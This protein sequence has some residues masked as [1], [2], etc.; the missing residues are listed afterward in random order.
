[1]AIQVKKPENKRRR[2]IDPVY[3]KFTAK[4]FQ[5]LTSTEFYDYFM[6]T[7]SQGNHNFQFTNKR[8]VKDV[9]TTWVDIIEATLPVL[10]EI[11]RN[12]RVVISQEEQ[13]I[14][15]V[16]ARRVDS[17]VVRH[18]CSHGNLVE[19]IDEDGNVIPSKIVNLFKE[20]SWDTYENRFVYTLLVK[21]FQFVD[22]R[23]QKIFNN[24]NDECG[25]NLIM[26][27]HAQTKLEILDMKMHL[28][29]QQIDDYEDTIDRKN[30][31][32]TRIKRMYEMLARLMDSRFAHEMN[33]FSPV[34]PPL[35]PTNA[36]KKN[37]LLRKCHVLWDFIWS[38]KDVGYSIEIVEQ[39]PEINE[40]FEQDIWN[41]I[42]FTYVILKGY[43]EDAR[44]RALDYGM[45]GKR[46]KFKPK[47]IK[48][49]V[50][51]LIKDYDLPD[52]EVRKVL[53]EELTKEQLLQ[54]EKEER[55]RLVEERER[56]KREKKRLEE[57]EKAR[58]QREKEKEQKRIALE[59]EKEKLRL[60]KEKE[61]EE[62]RLQREKVKKELSDA[63]KGDLFVAEI[64]K[65]QGAFEE[66]LNKKE[67]ARLKAEAAKTKAEA[68]KAA[69]KG[70][71][72]TTQET[73]EKMAEEL[74]EELAEDLAM[75]LQDELTDL[76][77]QAGD[78][79]LEMAYE[80]AEDIA[81]DISDKLFET[82]AEELEEEIVEEIEEH[83]TTDISDE[84]L[85]DAID[86]SLED[87]THEVMEDVQEIL[88]EA[89]TS[90][91]VEQLEQH[92]K[93]GLRERLK[94]WLN[95]NK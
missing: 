1:M 75:E 60:Q 79:S 38:Y 93:E 50:E 61:K 28:K 19:S 11:C 22:A 36:I 43:L 37:P 68:A 71:K 69:G 14:N 84:M 30:D 41:N 15:V 20:E 49:I 73:V 55:R 63:K 83:N 78:M 56:A 92:E 24:L 2:L 32:F 13:V 76:I 44:S 34:R 85:E 91:P 74:A 86:E 72:K 35:V 59:K 65:Q 90:L 9:D 33:K 67:A 18:L 6:A 45:K 80:I 42:M 23:Y 81:E 87:V 52:V 21:T 31:V 16:Q 47:Y 29:L 27:C 46:K 26:D 53:I 39:N 5:A 82:F 64:E 12:P 77:A 62:L 48:E 89:I 4:A 7:M 58:L 25:A 51:E 10:D 70:R 88:E 66:Y 40:K 95:R 3:K 8:I 54:E 57:I 94:N 17:H